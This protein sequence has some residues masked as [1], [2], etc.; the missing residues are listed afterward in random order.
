MAKKAPKKVTLKLAV[1]VDQ[2]GDVATS[3]NTGNLDNKKFHPVEDLDTGFSD[4][5]LSVYT[6]EVELAVPKPRTVKK[7]KVKKPKL[8]KEV[9]NTIP[10]AAFTDA[11]GYPTDD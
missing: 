6:F 4:G 11:S 10:A 9:D 1:A 7:L 5:V 8:V 2:Y 3:D